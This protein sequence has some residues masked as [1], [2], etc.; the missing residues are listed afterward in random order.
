M[1]KFR[2]VLYVSKGFPGRTNP[3]NYPFIGYKLASLNRKSIKAD[4]LW[5]KRITFKNRKSSAKIIRYILVSIFPYIHFEKNKF[6]GQEYRIFEIYYSCFSR[7][8]L[9]VIVS[10][11][12]RLNN[13]SLL[14]YHFLWSTGELV[15]LRKKVDIPAVISVRGSDMHE[16][17]AGDI[18]YYNLYKAAISKADKII[19][20]S[21]ALR[22]CA[23]ETGLGTD[24]DI[25]IHNGYDPGSFYLTRKESST[26]VF[27][28]VGHFYHVKRAEKLPL[29]FKHIKT[30]VP[31]AKMII[32]GSD[33]GKKKAG[34]HNEMLDGFRQFGLLEDVTLA[35]E[36]PPD[37]VVDYYAMMDVL[38]LPSRNE[39]FPNVAMEAKACGVAVAG[40]SNGGI[41]EAVGRGGVIVDE[42]EFFEERFAHA[43]VALYHRRHT[44]QEIHELVKPYTWDAVIS[45]EIEVYKNVLTTK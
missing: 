42:G 11:M 16:Y 2:N 40:S 25:V 45:K 38:L 23:V 7:F 12:R 13:Y 4:V 20:V 28:F 44:R 43:A 17:A 10:F 5:I 41:P 29:I 32:V 26:P 1:K 9:P 15:Y 34:L 27:G 3:S 18:K 24:R 14:H 21:D 31:L 6:T 39:G 35:G 8:W 19:Y 33:G 30:A 22:K 37:R 36:I